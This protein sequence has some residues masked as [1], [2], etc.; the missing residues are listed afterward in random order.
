MIISGEIL[1]KSGAEVT[2]FRSNQNIFTEGSKA[3]FYYQILEGI[4]KISNS[5]EDG[6]EFV[7]GFP[8]DGHYFGESYLFTE[9]KYAVSATALTY[10]KV[11]QL[12]KEKFIKLLIEKPDLH[13][14][15]NKYTADRL[16]FR[17]LI[18]SFLGISEPV[19]KVTK[20]L[21]H[22]KSYFE[23]PKKFTFQVPFI[24]QQLSS[25]IGIRVETLIRV[26]KILENQNKVIIKGKKIYY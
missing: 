12:C 5:F 1:I 3:K 26:I 6:K 14:A 16:H 11:D 23:C 9:N 2:I 22:L 17:Y 4:V 20:L 24:R 18:S 10:C 8:F 15:I 21:D 7:H 13:F 25:L 19:I